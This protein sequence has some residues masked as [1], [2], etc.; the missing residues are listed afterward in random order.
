MLTLFSV[1]IAFLHNAHRPTLAF[2]HKDT[3]GRH[4]STYEVIFHEKELK[5]PQG[6]HVE[7]KNLEEDTLSLFA[8]PGTNKGIL[9]CGLTILSYFDA[10]GL[11]ITASI[12]KENRGIGVAYAVLNDS[13]ELTKI[14]VG[15]LTGNLHLIC[16]KKCPVEKTDYSKVVEC[17]V[18]SLGRLAVASCV[19][20]N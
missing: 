4:I 15:D 7:L 8:V 19:S 20:I 12:R 9:S 16:L 13:R 14:L 5:V 11:L 18:I 10:D 1:S 3:S 17:A 6:K 2:L